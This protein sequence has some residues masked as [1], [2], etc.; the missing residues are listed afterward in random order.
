MVGNLPQLRFGKTWILLLNLDSHRKRPLP[1]H[2]NI[3]HKEPF[4][5]KGKTY[6]I[7]VFS[8]G[9]NMTTQAFIGDK[10]ANG[11]SHSITFPTAFGLKHQTGLEPMEDLIMLAREDI[12]EEK[13]EKLIKT[14]REESKREKRPRKE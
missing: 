13:W 3:I 2:M 12:E 7:R 4:T 5:H 1:G 6:E 9:H 8:D 10:V 14:C 11:Y